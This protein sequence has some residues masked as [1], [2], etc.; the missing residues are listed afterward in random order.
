MSALIVRPLCMAVPRELDDETLVLR[1]PADCTGMTAMVTASAEGE[2][3]V[4]YRGAAGHVHRTCR[5]VPLRAVLLD[6]EL[7]AQ[8]Q[9][10]APGSGR[11][12]VPGDRP[13]Q[14]WDV[15]QV[16]RPEQAGIDRALA[17][18]MAGAWPC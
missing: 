10:R 4:F 14:T 3:L 16:L 7:V 17:A 18:V 8:E 9:G 12:I 6:E 13:E 11:A 2:V 1:V 15:A 5:L